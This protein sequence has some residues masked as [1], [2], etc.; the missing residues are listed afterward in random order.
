MDFSLFDEASR[1][2]DAEAA[3]RRTALVRIAVQ[4]GAMPFLA[5]ASDEAE[6]GHRK[7]LMAERLSTIAAQCEAS[8]AEVEDTADRMYRLVL[9]TRQRGA[10]GLLRTA[11]MQCA[12]CQH[13]SVD[14]SEGLQC[15]QCGCANFTPQAKT[16]AREGEGGGPFS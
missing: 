10:E 9:A 1:D 3:E 15:P 5:L 11:A 16:A 7:A 8:V 2:H 13:G 4:H 6:Y 12:A 14:H